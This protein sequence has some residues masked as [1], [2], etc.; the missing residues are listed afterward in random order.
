MVR[1][2]RSS[3][4]LFEL[5]IRSLLDTDLYKFTMGFA[6]WL[7]FPKLRVEYRFVNRGKTPFPKGFANKLRMQIGAMANLKL[8]KTELDFLRKQGLFSEGYLAWLANYRYDPNEVIISQENGELKITIRGLWIRTI[9][10]EVPLMALISELYYLE[11]GRAAQEGW[12]EKARQKGLRLTQLMAL[13]MEFA[14]RRRFSFGV[15]DRVLQELIETA[16]L[17]SNGGALLGTSNVFL[18]MKY[19]IPVLGTVAHEWIMVFAALYGYLG[20]NA[21]AFEAWNKIYGDK[22]AI[23]LT[24]TFT[25]D[26]FLKEFGPIAE[27]YRGVR[28][29]SNGPLEI[30]DKVI[31]FYIREGFDPR[32]KIFLASDGLNIAMAERILIHAAG[33]IQCRF[34]IGTNLANDVGFAPLNMVIKLFGIFLE[35]GSFKPVVKLSDSKGKITGDQLEAIRAIRELGLARLY[36]LA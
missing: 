9:F 3:V 22:L 7:L 5:I 13:F 16:G 17:A 12:I 30:M 19:G 31:A 27:K 8:S 6:A 28:Q 23:A 11:T 32:E 33:R 21:R 24:D 18:A 10:W 29:D 35:D 25:T 2:I 26:V 1:A 15:Q 34:G 20:A 36:G 4:D 14:T